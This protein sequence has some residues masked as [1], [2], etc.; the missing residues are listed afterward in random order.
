[1]T[2]RSCFYRATGMSTDALLLTQSHGDGAL[3]RGATL[4]VPRQT[5]WRCGILRLYALP[6]AHR[7]FSQC[8]KA[9]LTEDT[10]APPLHA[11]P[12]MSSS[13]HPLLP[14][15]PANPSA[16]FLIP[17]VHEDEHTFHPHSSLS[18]ATNI[19]VRSAGVGLLVSATQNALDK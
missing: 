16:R 17:S 13:A 5:P 18:L 14:P 12:T 19:A 10:L 9:H 3:L 4:N 6:C 15:L 1:M 7:C 2:G 8:S 11:I